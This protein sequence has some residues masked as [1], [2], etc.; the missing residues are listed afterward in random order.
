MDDKKKNRLKKHYIHLAS[1]DKSFFAPEKISKLISEA[2]NKFSF[3][4][5]AE[6]WKLLGEANLLCFKQRSIDGYYAVALARAIQ[7]LAEDNYNNSLV[8][9]AQALYFEAIYDF[10]ISPNEYDK[11]I[12]PFLLEVLKDT[13]NL[14]E[15]YPEE[16]DRIFSEEVKKQDQNK[17]AKSPNDLLKKFKI[18]KI[19][20]D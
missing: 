5:S 4:N 1:K 17:I 11:M 15:K 6:S 12:P 20:K 14:S 19:I 3:G 9:L 2:K 7:L 18:N 10:K 13:L 8:Y 16:F